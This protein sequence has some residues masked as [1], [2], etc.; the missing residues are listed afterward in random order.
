MYKSFL[1]N[2]S[3]NLEYHFSWSDL[4]ETNIYVLSDI[5]IK[6][7]EEST[8]SKEKIFRF[9]YTNL[10]DVKVI[11]LGQDP[12]P[13]PG[14]ATGRSF[15]VANLKTWNDKIPQSSIRNILK[16]IYKTY[17]GELK[18]LSLIRKKIS[19]CEFTIEK[20]NKIFNSWESQGVLMLNTYLTCKIGKPN[21]HRQ[22]W[23]PFSKKVLEYIS[24]KNPTATWFLWGGQAQSQE[25]YIKNG[26]IYKANH[27]MILNPNNPSDLSNSNCFIDTKNRLN[28]NWLGS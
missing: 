15:E 18:P 5:L 3:F 14:I 27:P 16:V 25:K 28:I 20:P 19:N 4:F 11:I 9:A 2:N 6:L 13:Q 26:I 10:N 23:S 22:I 24:S 17:C 8:P 7:D 21:S 12:Y 1:L